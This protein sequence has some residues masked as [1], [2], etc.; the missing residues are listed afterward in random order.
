LL[1][2]VRTCRRTEHP[3]PPLRRSECG[4][5]WQM[6][7]CLTAVSGAQGRWHT[8]VLGI[9]RVVALSDFLRT[10]GESFR[11]LT[12]LPGRRSFLMR[13]YPI[14]NQSSF[15]GSIIYRVRLGRS[16]LCNPLFAS[17]VFAM[18]F[19]ALILAFSLALA[20]RAALLPQVRQA[21]LS[22]GLPDDAVRLLPVERKS[23]RILRSRTG[24]GT[25]KACV[26]SFVAAV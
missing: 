4:R 12:K 7:T 1:V 14:Q 21:S 26:V 3:E 16:G 13:P 25:V 24:K 9:E 17:T 8:G 6:S 18:T 15:C 11:S 19:R 2:G 23:V 20:G 10:Q 22:A 5:G